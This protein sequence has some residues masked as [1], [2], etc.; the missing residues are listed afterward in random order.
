MTCDRAEGRRRA[1]RAAASSDVGRFVDA[2]RCH[3]AGRSSVA[4]VTRSSAS[5]S[6]VARDSSAASVPVLSRDAASSSPE[7]GPEGRRRSD[8][9]PARLALQL[10]GGTAPADGTRPSACSRGL[11]LPLVCAVHDVPQLCSRSRSLPASSSAMRA[12]SACLAR[13]HV[14]LG[15]RGLRARKNPPRYGVPQS[16]RATRPR[17]LP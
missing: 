15:G 14:A 6:A 5:A 13:R 9:A 3:S 7:P 11:R 8:R 10:G 16:P 2:R 4:A 12:S 1:P 17:R